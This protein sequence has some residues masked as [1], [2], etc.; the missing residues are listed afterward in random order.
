MLALP[1]AAPQWIDWFPD[2]KQ[3][4]LGVPVAPDDVELFALP[5][6]GS[7]ARALGIHAWGATLSPDGTRIASFDEGGLRLSALDGSHMRRL[8]GTRE[9]AEFS[10]PVWSPDGRWIT[11]GVRGTGIIPAIR[12]VSTDG[13]TDVVLVEDPALATSTALL[14][15]IWLA[16][17]RLLY[18]TVAAGSSIIELLDVDLATARPRGAP[19]MLGTL[20]DVVGLESATRDGRHVLLSRGA[21]VNTE[22]RARLDQRDLDPQ[23][24]EHQGWRAFG[25]V[26]ERGETLAV[27]PGGTDHTEVIAVGANGQ[28]RTLAS[29]SSIVSPQIT[30]DGGAVLFLAVEGDHLVLRRIDLG[31]ASSAPVAVETLPYA[32]STPPEF[33]ER[34]VAQLGCPRQQ[35]RP[36]VLGATEGD[37]QVFYEIDPSKGRGR[38]LGALH[39]AS[40]WTWSLSA[41][42]AEIVAA[43]RDKDV[44]I[45]DV[46]SGESRQVIA[47]PG[48][49]VF[50]VAWIG[51]SRAFLLAGGQTRTGEIVRVEPSGTMR[52]VWSRPSETPGRLRVLEDAGSE[53]LVRTTSG[54]TSLGMIELSP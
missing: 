50:S 35:G 30:P 36:C 4:L 8:V 21:V 19:V 43:H 32:P 25:R 9:N 47:T 20:P 34:L 5:I 24:D 52:T 40:P 15:Y 38:R 46:A 11:Y 49:V 7:A 44:R 22:Y 27:A 45:L 1:G 37:D 6:D 10:W 48:L 18:R 14:A 3:L 12:V 13:S 26:P 2:G 16:D 31:G 28:P 29:L 39:G 54:T 41:D 53:L 23:P 17:G 42:G 51:A 33:T